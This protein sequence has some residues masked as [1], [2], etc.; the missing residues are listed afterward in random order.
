MSESMCF[1]R[2]RSRSVRCDAAKSFFD[3]WN[4][5]L[6]ASRPT[7]RTQQNGSVSAFDPCIHILAILKAGSL[8]VLMSTILPSQTLSSSLQRLKLSLNMLL[9]LNLQETGVL[10]Q[11]DALSQGIGEDFSA[12]KLKAFYSA[13]VWVI[14]DL[15]VSPS[16]RVNQPDLMNLL[17][18][19]KM[20]FKD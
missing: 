12:S 3:S 20:Y 15:M 19:S 16:L 8:C 17:Q 9:W 7:P 1:A 13:C 2:P 6:P 5:T 11:G 14:K 18:M 10:I 4:I